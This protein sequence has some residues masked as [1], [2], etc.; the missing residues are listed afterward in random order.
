MRNRTTIW[1]I[2]C[3]CAAGVIGALVWMTQHVI[4]ME[5]HDLEVRVQQDHEELV[6]LALWRMDAAAGQLLAVENARPFYEYDP[7]RADRMAELLGR[8]TEPTGSSNRRDTDREDS[9]T[10]LHFEI[11][12]SGRVTSPLWRGFDPANNSYVSKGGSWSPAEA[13]RLAQQNR[14]REMIP[15]NQTWQA[16]TS[17][18]AREQMALSQDRLPYDKLPPGGKQMVD[19]NPSINAPQG[20]SQSSQKGMQEIEQ[21]Q[22]SNWINQQRLTR[23]N[24]G[25]FFQ[26][27]SDIDGQQA[28][29]G[30]EQ[31]ER[32]AWSAETASV[33]LMQPRW[34]ED[35]LLLLRQVQLGRDE[36]LIQGVWLNW[37]E[38]QTWLTDQVV[39]LF[40]EAQLM[41][42]TVLED[43]ASQP[44]ANQLA[45]LPVALQVANPV[46]PDTLG[47]TA[48]HTMLTGVW[49][50]GLGLL[51]VTFFIVQSLLA[52]AE[53]RAAFVSAVTHE[54]RTPL[55]TFRLY[56]DLL[57]RS[58]IDSAAPEKQRNYLAV[59]RDESA[60]LI[61]LVENVLFYARL[62]KRKAAGRAQN[63]TVADLIEPMCGRLSRRLQQAGLDLEVDLPDALAM[64]EL[65]TDPTAVE[66]ILFNL[67]DNAAKYAAGAE[68]AVVQLSVR[69]EAN[70]L[71]FA[72]HDFGP[73]VP[74]H[75]QRKLFKPFSRSSEEAAGA[76]PGVGLGL[77]LSRR[78]AR[79]LGGNLT[80]REVTGTGCCFAL[81]LPV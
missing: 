2:Y 50:A 58:A 75:V 73:G 74:A 69:A 11:D 16:L 63:V 78:L 70:E 77:A 13:L 80:C 68:P 20:F 18:Y 8:P 34:C 57:D 43:D 17:D 4:G 79:S 67:V 49:I 22:T 61:H 25:R 5:Q 23:D 60:R 46:M 47:W 35:E 3:V 15:F 48:S 55:T 66:Q 28:P 42:L 59:L 71:Q 6:R 41:P 52:L 45:A 21:R 53:R 12:E 81:T 26:N 40:P 64:R 14:L 24:N 62:E 10:I 33:G 7:A 56:T 65:S 1:L 30:Q 9:L 29:G 36:Q 72:V 31:V 54:L 38:L 39:D 19:A 32:G 37:P 51:V 44:R 27:Q 76:A